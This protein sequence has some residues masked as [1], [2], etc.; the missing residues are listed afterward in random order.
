M[1][2]NRH[3]L[4]FINDFFERDRKNKSFS[5]SFFSSRRFFIALRIILKLRHASHK[6]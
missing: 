5:F 6:E 1:R 4:Q 3:G 2:D